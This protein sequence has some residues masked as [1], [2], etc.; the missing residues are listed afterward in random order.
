MKGGGGRQKETDGERGKKR[1]REGE[2]D[3]IR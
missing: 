2:N 1:E 3:R